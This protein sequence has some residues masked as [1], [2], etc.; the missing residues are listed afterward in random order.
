MPCSTRT[1]RYM[2]TY[3]RKL[4]ACLLELSDSESSSAAA[5][6]MHRWIT[7]L[8]SLTI[9]VSLGNPKGLKAFHSASMDGSSATVN[10]LPDSFYEDLLVGPYSPS[11]LRSQQEP[12]HASST[13]VHCSDHAFLFSPYAGTAELT[14]LSCLYACLVVA[15][16]THGH[17]PTQAI[18]YP[19]RQQHTGCAILL[20]C[21]PC[22]LPYAK[23]T[24]Q[25]CK[26]SDTCIRTC[27][28]ILHIPR[29]IMTEPLP[30]ALLACLSLMMPHLN[31]SLS[32]TAHARHD[33]NATDNTTVVSCQEQ[34]HHSHSYWP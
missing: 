21:M 34:A 15:G 2:Q 8:T 22:S 14:D 7:E 27:A 29:V 33:R 16:L 24:W 5:E 17:Q 23:V 19:C 11:G 10:Q 32:H 25:Q 4:G 12:E 6:D 13:V 3:A 9:C 18:C 28:A 1:P 26:C 30:H 20:S 31:H